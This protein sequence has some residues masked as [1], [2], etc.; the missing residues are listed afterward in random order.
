MALTGKEKARILLS[1]LGPE[2]LSKLL[3][4]LPE[5]LSSL[6]KAKV[7][8]LPPPSPEVLMSIVEEIQSIPALPKGRKPQLPEAETEKGR[9]GGGDILST[10]SKVLGSRLLSERPQT[11]AF[12]LSNFPKDKMKD[13]IEYLPEKRREVEVLLKSIKQ[14]SLSP[15]LKDLVFG[16]LVKG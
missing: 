11:I 5:E 4:L 14:N 16:A 13:I 1:M 12:I 2:S 9:T 8:K 3:K 6:L 10:P 7:K 15:M